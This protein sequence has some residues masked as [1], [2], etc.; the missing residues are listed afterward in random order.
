MVLSIVILDKKED[1]IQFLDPDLCK[2]EETIEEGGLRTLS[3][4]YQF[5]D[6]VEDKQL[7]KIGNKV[8]VSGDVNLSDC[9]YVINTEVTQDI[10]DENSFSLDLEEV[11]VELTYNIVYRIIPYPPRPQTPQNYTI[12]KTTT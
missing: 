4:T 1:F 7:F 5:K 10:Y 3:L 11:L 2:L 9:L 6:L 8:W 12:N